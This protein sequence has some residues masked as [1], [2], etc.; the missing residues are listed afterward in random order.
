M[1]KE[2]PEDRA[3]KPARQK[4]TKSSD[5]SRFPER[6]D[7]S[8][9]LEYNDFGRELIT[10]S[11]ERF[12]G[13]KAEIPIKNGGFLKGKS[14]GEVPN[15]YVA[16]RLALISTIA[17]DSQL[18]SGDIWPITP[19]QSELLFKE[20]KL[21]KPSKYW[22]DLGLVLYDTS[23]TGNNPREAQ[24]LYNSLT[25]HKSDLGLSQS[26]LSSKLL[27]VNA[28]LEIDPSMP[29]G[30]KPIVIPGVTQVYHP[31]IL[32]KIG[33]NHKF[34]YGLD[35]GFPKVDEI[36]SG[37]RTLYMPSGNDIGLRV[38]V[39]YW[40]SD[41][42]ARNRDLVNS[43]AVGRVNFAPQARSKSGGTR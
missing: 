18:R 19:L 35:N 34:E 17:D 37:K 43:V 26:D 30:V 27:V 3:K 42:Y 38:L 8:F 25:Q 39:R 22:E 33:S 12:K 40:D 1:N 24:S 21:P 14:E 28:G 15:M 6:V 32:E 9:L 20:G 29:H 5:P 36:G 7:S 11:N 13:T 23:P 31:E 41:L 4:T 16:K 2:M 10:K